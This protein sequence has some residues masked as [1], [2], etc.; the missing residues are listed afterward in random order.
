MPIYN[1][2]EYGDSYLKTSG[3]LLQYCRDELATD[4]NG[5]IVNFTVANSITDPSFQEVNRLFV[6]LLEDE[7]QRTTNKWYL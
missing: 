5:A 6:L 1:L 2:I 7:A 4:D 3:I